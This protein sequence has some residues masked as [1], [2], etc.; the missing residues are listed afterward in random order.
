MVHYLQLRGHL[1]VG[2]PGELEGVYYDGHEHVEHDHG[3]GE[4]EGEEEE[5]SEHPV[6]KVQV[7][8]LKLSHEGHNHRNERLGEG[9]E[10]FDRG[11]ES[12]VGEP[13]VGDGDHE[14]DHEEM[15]DR[16]TCVLQG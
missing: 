10:A 5:G 7:L 6:D 12:Q 16:G 9:P 15:K 13:A 8:E 4:V 11:A 3:H 14:Q 2:G 1:Y